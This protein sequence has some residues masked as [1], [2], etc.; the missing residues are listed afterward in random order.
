MEQQANINVDQDKID[1]KYSDQVFINFN[2]FGFTFDFAQAV[3]QMN[4]VRVLSR[5]AMSPQH[6]KALSE[7]LKQTIENYEKGF[8]NIEITKQ[9]QEQVTPKEGLGFKISNS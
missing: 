3:P 8:G 2:P 7:V 5:I 4:M 6:V 9:M 1:A